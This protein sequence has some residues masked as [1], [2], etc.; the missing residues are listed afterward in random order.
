MLFHEAL[1]FVFTTFTRQVLQQGRLTHYL[2][3]CGVFETFDERKQLCQILDQQYFRRMYDCLSHLPYKQQYDAI[4]QEV[5]A[6]YPQFAPE[7]VQYVFDSVRFAYG[8]IKRIKI[9]KKIDLFPTPKLPKKTAPKQKRRHVQRKKTAPRN[10][11]PYHR[12]PS[13]RHTPRPQ[14]A[15][16][17]RPQTYPTTPPPTPKQDR[18]RIEQIVLSILIIILIGAGNILMTE[19]KMPVVVILYAVAAL[20]TLIRFTILK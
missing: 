9:P 14:R 15:A 7:Q 19:D 2:A 6:A 5:L 12:H 11:A 18:R 8:K 1:H 10:I 4:L 3:D 20:L 13:T 16:N 17:A